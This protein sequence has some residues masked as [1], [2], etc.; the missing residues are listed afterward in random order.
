MGVLGGVDT[1][2]DALQITLANEC[3]GP[4]TLKGAHNLQHTAATK[5]LL[6]FN[7]RSQFVINFQCEI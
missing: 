5:T 2:P 7:E 4:L 6:F 1:T 3:Y